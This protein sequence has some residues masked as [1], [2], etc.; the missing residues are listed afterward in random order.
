VSSRARSL[1]SANCRAHS[2][3]VGRM[4]RP[5]RALPTTDAERERSE[6]PDDPPPPPPDDPPPPP[7]DDDPAGTFGS[8][9]PPREPAPQPH[10]PSGG[11]AFPSEEEAEPE[12]PADEGFPP[13]PVR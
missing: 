7:P 3:S 4:V 5:V 10:V 12:P 2:R 8:G 1:A 9:R 13:P 11:R 6:P